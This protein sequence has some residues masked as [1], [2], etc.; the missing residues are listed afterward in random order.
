MAKPAYNKLALMLISQVL[1]CS[2]IQDDCADIHGFSQQTMSRICRRVATA[3]AR[4]APQHIKMPHT[5]GEQQATAAEFY[6]IKRFP[7]VMGAIDCTHIKI[8][9][10][11]G[12]AGQYYINRK[13]YYSLNV[14]VCKVKPT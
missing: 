1:I 8:R 12:D 14:Q 3:F 7:G 10:V 13:G 5:V 11:G 6:R 2:Q 9:K 4:L